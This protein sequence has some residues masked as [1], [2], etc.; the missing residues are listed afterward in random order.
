ML[1]DWKKIQ[2]FL[3]A[4]KDAPQPVR[5]LIV[6][7]LCLGL[8]PEERYALDYEDLDLHHGTVTIKGAYVTAG[9]CT[10]P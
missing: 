5:R 8:R 4:T 2:R 10:V 1:T 6:S 7:G 9:R 3:K